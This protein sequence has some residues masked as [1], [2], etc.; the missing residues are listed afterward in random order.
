MWVSR[1][2]GQIYKYFTELTEIS[3]GSILEVYMTICFGQGLSSMGMGGI[4]KYGKT[5]ST[6][7]GLL[8][9]S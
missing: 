8:N 7:K 6:G 2:G 5:P 4:L 1:R 9:H 3:S